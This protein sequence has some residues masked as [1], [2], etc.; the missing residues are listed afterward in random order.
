MIRYC[1]VT[2]LLVCVVQQ[3][4]VDVAACAE[5]DPPAHTT[6]WPGRA[7][8]E[9]TV[10]GWVDRSAR[11]YGIDDADRKRLRDEV[12][13]LWTNQLAGRRSVLEPLLAEFIEARLGAHPPSQSEIRAWSERALPAWR[14]LQAVMT[15]TIA[16]MD[17][18]VPAA[19]RPLFEAD[20]RAMDRESRSF[21]DR[22]QA[23]S[24]GEYTL[25]EWWEPAQRDAQRKTQDNA[26]R[27]TGHP[28]HTQPPPDTPM[29]VATPLVVLTPHR[30]L[31]VIEAE[32]ERWQTFVDNFAERYKLSPPQRVSAESILRECRTLAMEHRR[33]HRLDLERLEMRL[34]DASQDSTEIKAAL[35][36]LYG[37]IDAMFS[38]LQTRLQALLTSAQQSS[39][40]ATATSDATAT[41]D[42]TATTSATA[43]KAAK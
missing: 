3:V 38:R 24:R 37:P 14:A 34:A 27:S 31:D 22:L 8:I 6:F 40:D 33:S 12:V 29:P 23:W 15:D 43:T 30:A 25:G 36:R 42:A 18:V 19:S 1:S 32:L 21:D 9:S 5:N 35:N 39:P 41:P 11:Q 17:A 28:Q 16:R 4:C 26:Q 7:L 2:V 13:D 10:A 20:R